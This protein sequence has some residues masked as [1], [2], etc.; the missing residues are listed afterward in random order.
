LL[1]VFLIGLFFHNSTRLQSYE[2]HNAQL[3][4]IH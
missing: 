3:L 4:C 1:S 2:L